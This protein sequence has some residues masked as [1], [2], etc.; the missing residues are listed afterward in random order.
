MILTDAGERRQ[1]DSVSLT[2]LARESRDL[3]LRRLDALRRRGQLVLQSD[4]PQLDWGS[5][6]EEFLE[7]LRA[8]DGVVFSRARVALALPVLHH[9]RRKRRQVT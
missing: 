9:P 7:S 2:D 4:W 1:S 5:A 3:F 6:W 8:I